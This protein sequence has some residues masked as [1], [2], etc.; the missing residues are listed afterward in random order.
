MG[1][2]ITIRLATQK[3]I[4]KAMK[5]SDGAFEGAWDGDRTIYIYRGLSSKRRRLVLF[6]ELQ[7]ALLDL[8]DAESL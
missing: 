6:H 3:E 7:H 5:D 2:T 8:R 1:Y 4:Q